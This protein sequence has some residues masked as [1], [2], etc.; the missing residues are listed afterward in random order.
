MSSI[1]EYTH[2]PNVA[3]YLHVAFS[4]YAALSLNRLPRHVVIHLL[5]ILWRYQYLDY[6]RWLS[7]HKYDVEKCF[8]LACRSKQNTCM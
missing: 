4:W 5:L 1:I 6:I 7:S 2:F 8:N 3:W